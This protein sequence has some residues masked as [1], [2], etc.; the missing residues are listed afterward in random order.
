MSIK[1]EKLSY[2]YQPET[3]FEHQALKE[4]SFEIKS[5]SYTAIVG[6]TGSG[7]STLLQHLNGLLKPTQGTLTVNGKK[8]DSTTQNKQLNALRQEVGFVFQFPEA[9]LFEET[10]LKDIAFA[11]QNFGKTQEEAIEIAK[12]KAKMVGIGS[13][14]WEKSPFELSGGQMRRVAIAGILAMSPKV[15]ILDEPT[16]GLDPKGRKEMMEMFWRLHQEENLTIILVTHQMNDVANYADHVVVLEHGQVIADT[17]P[18][19]LFSQP[20][21]LEQHHLNLPQ[22]TAFAWKL[23]Q[24]G[25]NLEPLPLTEEQLA[26]QLAKL[27]KE[28]ATRE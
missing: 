4:I 24:R 25:L 2:T 15:L 18:D 10:V 21:W 26:L 9:Q 20:T 1:I 28:D 5:G 23:K 22:T 8:I 19:E 3:P 27:L 6:H 7:K 14:L 17:T 13:D 16:A 12:Q 11:P